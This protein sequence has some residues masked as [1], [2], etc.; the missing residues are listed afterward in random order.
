[1]Q[2]CTSANGSFPAE[3]FARAADGIVLG[4]T[5]VTDVIDVSAD[6]GCKELGIESWRFRPWSAIQP[7]PI[8]EGERF[9]FLR[10]LGRC[11][12]RLRTFLCFLDQCLVRSNNF[13]GSLR[14]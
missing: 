11:G 14:N 4:V 2:H 10:L 12:L 3:N 8:R 6:F 1:M 5:E 9:G 13:W 7:G